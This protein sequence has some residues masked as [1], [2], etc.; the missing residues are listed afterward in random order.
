MKPVR[1]IAW[2]AL[3]VLVLSGSGVMS[4]YA[5]SDLVPVKSSL[6]APININKASIEELQGISGIGQVIA[7]RVVEYRE[8]NGKFEVLEDLMDVRGIGQAKFERI[9]GQ[10]TI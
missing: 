4:L 2:I 7:E 1:F 8:S 6:A 10:I 5:Q 3:A 9:K